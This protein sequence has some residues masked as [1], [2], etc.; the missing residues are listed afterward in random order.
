MENTNLDNAELRLEDLNSIVGGAA[1]D[2]NSMYSK[3]AKAVYDMPCSTQKTLA[4]V[5]LTKLVS[6]KSGD[7]GYKDLMQRFNL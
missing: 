4:I 6:T 7:R 2:E 3:C 5:E 1:A